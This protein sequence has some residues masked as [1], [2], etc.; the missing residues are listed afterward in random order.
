MDSQRLQTVSFLSKKWSEKESSWKC[1]DQELGL[2]VVVQAFIEWRAWPINTADTVVFSDHANLKY[3]S[4]NQHLL[5]QQGRWASF[6]LSIHFFIKHV[7]GQLNLVD[8]PTRRTDFLP[9]GVEDQSPQVM[10]VD[11]GTGLRVVYS[12][13]DDTDP[14]LD[15]RE[16]HA[17]PDVQPVLSPPDLLA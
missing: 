17:V 5:E 14:L 1:H 3:L 4:A 12:S 11:D 15:S 9:N 13:L 2:G 6:L 8:P 10:M 7:S 16:V